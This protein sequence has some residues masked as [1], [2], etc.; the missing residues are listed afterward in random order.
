V[1]PDAG[2]V[3]ELPTPAVDR[4]VFKAGGDKNP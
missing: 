4:P 3:S 2:F 1:D